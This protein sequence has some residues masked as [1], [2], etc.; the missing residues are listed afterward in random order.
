MLYKEN[1]KEEITQAYDDDEKVLKIMDVTED[2]EKKHAQLLRTDLQLETSYQ[3]LLQFLL[4]FLSKTKTATT[5]GLESMFRKTSP[6]VLI[7]SILWSMR[8]SASHTINVI[9]LQKG[10][11]PMVSKL[12]MVVFAFFAT[13]TKLI[14]NVSFF[15]PSFGL[16]DLLHHWEAEQIPFFA[17]KSGKLNASNG[18]LL[19]LFNTTP[20]PWALVD[21]WNYQDQEFPPY[22]DLYTGMS[23][24]W[25]FNIFLLLNAIHTLTIFIAKHITSPSFRK[26]NIVKRIVNSMETSHVPLPFEDWDNEGGS[27]LEHKQRRKEVV[28]EVLSVI[29]VNKLFSLFM[30]VPLIYTGKYPHQEIHIFYF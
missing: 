8:S 13:A 7:V 28:G 24:A 6:A 12:L 14:A 29:A 18:D 21:R 3:L 20:V 23:L 1:L 30:F 2:L 11:F 27:I 16:F 10:H 15:I 26:A 5:K 22:Y 17:S 25:T 19:Y 4:L 9:A